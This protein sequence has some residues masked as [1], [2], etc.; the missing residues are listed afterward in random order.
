MTH[1]LY[2]SIISTGFLLS[3]GEDMAAQTIAK[4]FQQECETF[5][6]FKIDNWLG[7]DGKPTVDFNASGEGITNYY[8]PNYKPSVGLAQTIYIGNYA[9]SIGVVGGDGT[10][11]I[12]LDLSYYYETST[13]KIHYSYTNANDYGQIETK[14]SGTEEDYF[15]QSTIH[16]K[17]FSLEFEKEMYEFFQE[18]KKHFA[19]KSR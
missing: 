4:H 5:R 13:L 19:Y 18:V 7:P 14:I 16:E 10:G 3:K 2:L 1:D 8:S 6:T 17:L 9:T 11:D 15:Q 12:E